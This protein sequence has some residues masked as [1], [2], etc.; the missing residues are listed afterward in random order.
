MSPRGW[1]VALVAAVLLAAAAVPGAAVAQTPDQTINAQTDPT[2][3]VAALNS[4]CADNINNCTLAGISV[5]NGY[6]APQIL[7]DVLYNCAPPG[8]PN[9]YTGTSVSAT[10]GETTGLSES[11]SVTLQGGLIGVASASAEFKAFSSQSEGFT[12]TVT[13]GTSI[14]VP[15]GYKGYTTTQVLSADATTSYYVTDGIH[16]IDVTNL[17][18]SIPGYQNPSTNGND[19]QT[20]YNLITVPIDPFF[21]LGPHDPGYQL[22]A[23]CTAVSDAPDT[24]VVGGGLG[25]VQQKRQIGRFKFTLCTP[26]R[27]CVTHSLRGAPPAQMRRATAKLARGGRTYATGTDI[28][29][30]IRLTELRKITGGMYQLTIKQKPRR[31]KERR[32]GGRPAE[33]RVV[34]RVPINVC[35][36]SPSA[37]PRFGNPCTNAKS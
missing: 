26:G 5:T 14:P 11:L 29:G 13:Q 24:T 7:G 1:S 36:N 4:G 6:D 9:A 10:R 15:P 3:A 23:P 20:I 35:G 17:D 12:A 2:D 33:Q 30:H 8:G 18:L 25:G 31:F 19:A 28:R 27:R 37:G 16:L 21:P 32:N 22:S 34:I